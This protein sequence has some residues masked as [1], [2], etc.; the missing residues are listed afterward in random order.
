MDKSELDRIEKIAVNVLLKLARDSAIHEFVAVQ[1][2]A[3]RDLLDWVDRYRAR[4]E[5]GEENP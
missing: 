1:R 3:A 2:E 4:S 5:L